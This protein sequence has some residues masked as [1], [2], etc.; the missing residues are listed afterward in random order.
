MLSVLA[1][2][3]NVPVFAPRH[4]VSR[5]HIDHN[6]E[7]AAVAKEE[8]FDNW[9]SAFLFP[10]PTRLGARKEA[11]L[12]VLNTWTLERIDNS[13]NRY[14]VRNPYYWKI[15][16][17][18]NQL[19]YIDEHIAVFV[20]DVEVLVLKEIAGGDRLLGNLAPHGQRAAVPRE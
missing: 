15:D 5:W 18:G 1:T 20:E 7:A 8:G 13:N 14:F 16:T 19:P 12:P 3:I 17:A 9:W 11:E 4:Y 10:N 6:E 2:L